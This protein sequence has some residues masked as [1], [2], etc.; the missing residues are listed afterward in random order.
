MIAGTRRW[1]MVVAL[2]LAGCAQGSPGEGPIGEQPGPGPDAAGPANNPNDVDNDGFEV[3]VDCNDNNPNVNPSALESCDS[4]D[5]DCDGDVDEEAFDA[6]TY[7]AD[8]DGDGYGDPDASVDACN[9]PA[10]HVANDDDCYDDNAEVNPGQTGFFTTDRGD[11][12]FDWDC[13]GG[14]D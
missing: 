1:L 13:S 2:V 3:G 10:D 14:V 8:T 7:Y 12:S 6:S 5:Q 9:P 4:V 11:G